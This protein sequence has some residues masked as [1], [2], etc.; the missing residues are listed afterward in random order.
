MNG[1]I[2]LLPVAL[3]AGGLM[4]AF[5]G[6]AW[7]QSCPPNSRHVGQRLDGDK[8][9][10]R[11]ACDAGFITTQK[12]CKTIDDA[13]REFYLTTE[14]VLAAVARTFDAEE[15]LEASADERLS[16][17]DRVVAWAAYIAALNGQASAVQAI[18]EMAD[19]DVT[20][21]LAFVAARK[22]AAAEATR[23]VAQTWMLLRPEVRAPFVELA[24][25]Y[26][27]MKAR[28]AYLLGVLSF[29]SGQYD[30]ALAYFKDAQKVL[31]GDKGIDESLLIVRLT[32]RSQWEARHPKAAR[33]QEARAF[34]AGG[35]QAAWLMGMHLMARNDNAGAEIFLRE[36]GVRMRHV[37]GRGA[38]VDLIDG[39]AAKA[40]A[41]REAGKPG[42]RAAGALDGWS[43]VD[44]MLTACEYGQ[45][46]WE[47]SLRFLETLM[48]IDRSN[49]TVAEAYRELKDIAAS[50]Q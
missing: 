27:P 15:L 13:A 1:P 8:L 26:M 18:V 37:K 32:Q 23:Q 40:R 28:A 2:R 33:L 19:P 50:A 6:A 45:K 47:R 46:D 5:P 44:L 41:D 25:G 48:L 20:G 12:A 17:K 35:A 24:S 10:I 42:S 4:A 3:L 39:L 9:I 14:E 21:S 16:L 49:P 22:K 29:R 36:A 11:C 38:D 30:S 43:K 7:P 34:R 31:P